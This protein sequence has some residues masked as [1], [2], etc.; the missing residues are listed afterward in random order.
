ME[1]S[2]ASR[3]RRLWLVSLGILVTVGLICP[4]VGGMGLDLRAVFAGQAP[5]SGIFW[6]LRLPRTLLALLTGAAL[7]ASGALFQA[8]MRDALATPS[9]L[10]VTAAASLG[11]VIAISVVPRTA[12]DFPLVWLSSVAGAGV[13]MLIVI[14]MARR[15]RSYWTLLLT[16][17]AMN[18]ICA[19]LVLFLHSLA[20]ITRSF[21]I[22]HW[23]MGG[24]DAVSYPVLAA[25]A[26][27]IALA[28]VWLLRISRTLNVIALGEAWAMGR[29]VHYRD[30][31]WRGYAVGTLLVGT[32]T[33]I[34]GPISFV[35][36]IVPHILRRIL[37]PDYRLLIPASIFLGAAFLA[38]CDT[39]A[40]TIL[41]P[42]EVPV[43]VITALLGGPFFVWL[44]WSR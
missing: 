23:L 29:G 19:A 4:F 33:A 9:N 15:S 39:F 41:A 2:L 30:I 7:S 42:A 37:G 18:G 22:T 35:G 3:V 14:A 43:G 11:A 16:G 21:Q 31:S 44:L 6:N 38:I 36:L 5:D 20:G 8:L 25:I 24:L 10:G 17:I 26:I 28:F 27:P 32:T 12:V 34:T 40:R 1:I 13:V